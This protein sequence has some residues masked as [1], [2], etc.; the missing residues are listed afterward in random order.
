MRRV[1]SLKASTMVVGGF[2]VMVFMDRWSAMDRRPR[3]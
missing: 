2:T 1:A 3:R